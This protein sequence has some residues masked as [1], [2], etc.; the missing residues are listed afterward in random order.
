MS[1]GAALLSVL[2]SITAAAQ[3]VVPDRELEIVR[4]NFNVGNYRDALTRARN[5]MEVSNFNEA[6]RVEL[7]KYAGLSAFNLGELP[8]AE[9]HFYSLLQL[10]PDYVLDPFAYPPP[11]IRL[12]EDVKKRSA[13]ALNLVRQQIALR[14]EQLRREAA[15][16]EKA[17]VLEEEA[18]RRLEQQAQ[19][20]TVRTIEK[21]SLLVNLIPFGA[22]Q[23]QQGR[24]GLGVLFAS[25]EFTLGVLSVVAYGI[26]ESLFQNVTYEFDNRIFPEDGKFTVTVRR[27]PAS[28]KNSAEGWRITKVAS[29]VGFYSVWAIGVAEALIRHK[30]EVVT[31]EIKK[32]DQKPAPKPELAPK[33]FFF[34][35]AGGLGA[36]VSMS[37]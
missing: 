2:L 18:R 4:Q 15:E 32:L 20:V 7:H 37:F 30:D 23:F 11:A 35:T 27:I 33:V 16:R 17:R 28:L 36:G 10:N 6:Q 29:G 34:P 22:G 3:A 14:E 24:T 1:R 21:R 13:E 9:K 8:A 31:T 12:F 5:A 19:E 25:V 26:I